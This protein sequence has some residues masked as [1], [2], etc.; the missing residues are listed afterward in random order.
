MQEEQIMQARTIQPTSA[1]DN[2]RSP[3]S[4]SIVTNKIH[5]MVVTEY[6]NA[7]SLWLK[8]RAR[9]QQGYKRRKMER[10]ALLMNTW[11]IIEVGECQM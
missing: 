10:F 11:R 9:L 6:Q 4:Q 8:Q 3:L 7:W 2:E 5:L 1:N